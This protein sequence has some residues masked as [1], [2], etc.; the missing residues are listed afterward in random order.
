MFFLIGDVL[1][2]RF[3]VSG[4]DGERTVTVLPVKVGEVWAF[5]FAPFRGLPFQFAD[6]HGHGVGA[7]EAA[8]DVNVI[9]DAADDDGGGIEILTGAGEIGVQLGTHGR[10]GQKRLPIFRGVDEVQIDLR[11]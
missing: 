5:L 8:E 1:F 9:R 2:Q 3:D 6:Q 10:I 11:E 7:R 4:T